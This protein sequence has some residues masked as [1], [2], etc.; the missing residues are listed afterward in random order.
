MH[1][2]RF[3]HG[4]RPIVLLHGLGTSNFLWREVAPELARASHTALAVDL[5]G[6]GESDRPYDGEY[7]IAAQGGY[8]DRV[9]TA[10]RIPRATIVGCD[11]GALIAL[12]L[13]LSHPDRVERLVLVSP[14]DIDDIPGE[15][16]KLFQRA[17][18][19]APIRQQRGVLGASPL[20]RPLLE[21]SVAEPQAM[22]EGLVAR[23][24][25][26]YVGREGVD[27][28]HTIMRSLRAQ[29]LHE[30]ELRS[31]AAPTLIVAGDRD[32]WLDLKTAERLAGTIPEARLERV[33][34]AGRL[35]PE[36]A[37]DELTEL[38]LRFD[39]GR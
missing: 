12:R 5:F 26:P 21:A 15:D 23:Y 18:R 38:I 1:V 10:L 19:R 11:L 30:E 7:G 37:P 36:E 25:A 33:A 27:Q 6:H 16:V 2:A 14:A 17:V 29:D 9:L 22:P 28:L 13:A 3:G 4:G 24:L 32:R 31:V 35:I 39:E 8:L 34:G 20:L